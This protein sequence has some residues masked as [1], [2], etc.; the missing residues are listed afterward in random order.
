MRARVVLTTDPRA[1]LPF[2]ARSPLVDSIAARNDFVA[3]QNRYAAPT[4]FNVLSKSGLRW[5]S[6]PKPAVPAVIK[7]MS[8]K[9]QITTTSST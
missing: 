6:A 8:A 9:M 1:R 3:N 5:T 7:K 2:S 4:H